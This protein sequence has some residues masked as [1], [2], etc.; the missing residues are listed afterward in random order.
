MLQESAEVRE[1]VAVGA[2]LYGAIVAAAAVLTWS[3]EADGVGGARVE[4]Q[5]RGEPLPTGEIEHHVQML[6]A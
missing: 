5:Q 1:F 6:G 4:R 2:V 3:T